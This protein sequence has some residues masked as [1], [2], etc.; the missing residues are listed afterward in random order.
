MKAAEGK[1]KSYTDQRR[2]PLEFEEEDKVF[3][4]VSPIKGV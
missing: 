4:K 3:L 1:P 2:K